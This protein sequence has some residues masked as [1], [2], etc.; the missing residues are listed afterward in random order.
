M[1]KTHLHEIIL[2][3]GC[4]AFLTESVILRPYRRLAIYPETTTDYS[5]SD[6]LQDEGKDFWRPGSGKSNS[7]TVYRTRHVSGKFRPSPRRCCQVGQRAAH[8]QMNCDITILA[9][10]RK[11]HSTLWM[12][13]QPA[14][15]SQS[16]EW[17]GYIYK[18]RLSEKV[19]KCS[20][21][22]PKQFEKC[23][24]AED[25]VL[26]RMRSC[27]LMAASR[28]ERRRCRKTYKRRKWK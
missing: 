21:A 24:E 1:W 14:S 27:E 22:Q 9:M 25:S 16:K 6:T 7:R 12:S 15:Q 19:A 5:D 20:A 10:L 18:S 11:F 28:A 17:T 13:Q 4:F 8:K 26:R 3:L 23:C 2:I